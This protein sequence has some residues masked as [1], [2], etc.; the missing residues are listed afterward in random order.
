MVLNSEGKVVTLWARSSAAGDMNM[1]M[2]RIQIPSHLLPL[3]REVVCKHGIEIGR[4]VAT[5]G[6][7][8][9]TDDQR[10]NL[11]NAIAAEFTG[12]GLRS[13]FEPNQLGLELEALLDRINAAKADG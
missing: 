1:R 4:S 12:T 2:F 8:E 9:L 5:D 13:D 3:L 6:F 7:L 10:T 11:I